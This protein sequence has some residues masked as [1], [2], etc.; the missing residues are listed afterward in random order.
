VC[1]GDSFGTGSRGFGFYKRTPSDNSAMTYLPTDRPLQILT[2]ADVPPDPNSGAAGT[3]YCTNVALRELGHKTDE[4][5]AEQLGPRR[6]R[7]GNLHSLLEQPRT[8]RR[9]VL[10]AI[11]RSTYDVVL[12]SQPQ[13]YLAARMLKKAGFPG[14]VV[15]R[16]HGVE[17]RVDAVLP[18]WHRRL[19]VPESRCPLLSRLVRPWLHR[20]WSQILQWT[21][22]VVTG[23]ALDREFLLQKR[24]ANPETVRAIPHGVGAP[25]LDGPLPASDPNRMN[26]LHVGQFAFI[27]GVDVLVDI[28]H[29]VL[30]GDLDSQFTWVCSATHHPLI[31]QRLAAEVRGRVALCPWMSMPELRTVYDQHGVFVFPSLFEGFGKAPFEAMARG[32]CVVAADEGGMHDH[33]RNGQNGYL[34]PVGDVSAAVEVLTRLRGD[35]SLVRRVG[36]PAMKTARALTWSATANRLVAFFRE[37]AGKQA[38]GR[39]PRVE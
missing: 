24:A 32:L 38:T 14:T 10:K 5:W 18:A 25:F 2:V 23:C 28:I 1:S 34:F 20:Q 39:V 35:T 21:D 31:R 26:L 11:A 7:H 27:K 37:L 30:R 29:R 16:S 4:I 9:E 6:I 36:Q 8:Y 12:M 33:I 3:V 19:A 17:L 22:G 13:A 15:N